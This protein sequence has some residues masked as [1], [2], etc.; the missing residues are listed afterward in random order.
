MD[1]LSIEELVNASNGDLTSKSK[2]VES[3]ND[4]VIDSRLA[5]KNNAFFA[6]IGESLD[7]HKFINSAIENG[8]KTIIKNKSND[9]EI[10]GEDVNII[11]VENTEFALGDISRYYKNKFDIPFIGVTGSVGKTSTRDM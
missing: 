8:C 2:E 3:I 5:N 11:E 4:L 7:G 10:I 6:I 1:Y 9:L